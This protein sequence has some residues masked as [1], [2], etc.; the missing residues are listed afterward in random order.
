MLP[1]FSDTEK[2]SR[3]S[4]HHHAIHKTLP[5]S[6]YESC[7]IFAYIAFCEDEGKARKMCTFGVFLRCF[8]D[9]LACVHGY[10]MWGEREA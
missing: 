6:S 9:M 1:R 2:A 7:L 10:S 8:Y 5:L 3:E 4:H